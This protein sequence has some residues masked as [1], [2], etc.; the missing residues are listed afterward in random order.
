MTFLRSPLESGKLALTFLI[1]V[2]LP[3]CA[4]PAGVQEPQYNGHGVDYWLERMDE[5]L[6]EENLKSL[7]PVIALAESGSEAERRL[8]QLWNDRN[9]AVR[10]TIVRNLGRMQQE[11]Q[12]QFIPMVIGLLPSVEP[13]I[14]ADALHHLIYADLKRETEILAFREALKTSQLPD[15]SYIW[16]EFFPQAESLTRAGPEVPPR[17]AKLAVELA[18]AGL[19]HSDNHNFNGYRILSSVLSFNKDFKG[20]IEAAEAAL[21]HRCSES[22]KEMMEEWIEHLRELADQS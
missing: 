16:R 4:S 2:F 5:E 14:A 12:D 22:E 15:D 9:S 19:R 6:P 17:K 20:A 7:Y 10:T 13:R 18:E 3:Q 21:Q 11:V 1:L 8:L